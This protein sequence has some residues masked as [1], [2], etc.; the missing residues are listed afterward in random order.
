MVSGDPSHSQAGERLN[1]ALSPKSL[2]RSPFIGSLNFILETKC[3]AALLSAVGILAIL[4]I[5]LESSRNK[6]GSE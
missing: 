1:Q 2:I 6:G 3:S 4:E 5:F